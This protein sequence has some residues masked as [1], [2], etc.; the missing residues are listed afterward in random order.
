MMPQIGIMQGRLS[1]PQDGRFQFSPKNW[2][3]EFLLAKEL[4]FG[5]IEWI[6]EDDNTEINPIFDYKIR[7]EIQN[8]SRQH[9]VEINSLCADYF[10]NHDLLTIDNI[11]FLKV[12]MLVAKSSGIKTIVLPFL[13]GSDIKSRK[14]EKKVI[15]NISTVSGICHS[16]GIK[17]ALETELDAKNLKMFIKEFDSPY[18]GVCYDLGNTAS[19]GHNSPWDI[20]LLGDLIFEVHVKDRKVGSSQSVYLGE[21][22]VDFDGCFKALKNIGFNG[23]MILQANRGEDYLADAKRQLEFVKAKWRK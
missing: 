10:I 19:Y 23:P 22:D 11:L 20:R 6:F 1:P 21:G 15:K 13:E 9:N 17:L 3:A 12:L 14:Q 4:G 16:Y 5:S 8:L 2:Q 18:V 7:K